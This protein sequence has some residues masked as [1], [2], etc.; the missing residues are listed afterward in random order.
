MAPPPPVRLNAESNSDSVPILLKTPYDIQE[1]S[2]SRHQ[3]VIA[4]G[5]SRWDRD[6][7]QLAPLSVGVRFRSHVTIASQ[8][9][10]NRS[11]ANCLNIIFGIPRRCPLS[12]LISSIS[13]S[14]R[15]ALSLDAM[16][17][18]RH[19]PPM[20]LASCVERSASGQA[21]QPEPWQ[22]R[23]NRHCAAT[24]RLV[25]KMPEILSPS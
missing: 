13:E 1:S 6:P 12:P 8:G 4:Y 17:C 21:I 15:T 3:P 18:N 23:K 25:R 20:N 5:W 22:A 7:K 11:V 2:S 24:F 9:S 19:D 14:L 16:R 10:V